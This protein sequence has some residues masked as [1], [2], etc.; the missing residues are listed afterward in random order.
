MVTQRRQQRADVFQPIGRESVSAARY[1]TQAGLVDTA[2]NIMKNLSGKDDRKPPEKAKTIQDAI[3]RGFRTNGE[4]DDKSRFKR[5]TW[6]KYVEG[7]TF[8]ELSEMMEGH[9]GFDE[10]QFE[11]FK[12]WYPKWGEAPDLKK[13][14]LQMVEAGIKAGDYPMTRKQKGKYSKYQLQDILKDRYGVDA[15]AMMTDADYISLDHIREKQFAENLIHDSMEKSPVPDMRWLKSR[16]S[17]LQKEGV[18]DKR[19]AA[20]IRSRAYKT[21]AGYMA[22][23]QNMELRGL[24]MKQLKDGLAD[25]ESMGSVLHL[26]DSALNGEFTM[27]E[28]D[29]TMRDLFR[30]SPLNNWQMQTK[31]AGIRAGV[32]RQIVE[33]VWHKKV[34]KGTGMVPQPIPLG[35]AG[36]PEFTQGLYSE[37]AQL[38]QGETGQSF[39][40]LPKEKRLAYIHSVIR[41]GNTMKLTTQT[42]AMLLKVGNA[43]DI[44]PADMAR[45]VLSTKNDRTVMKEAFHDIVNRRKSWRGMKENDIKDFTKFFGVKSDP[46]PVQKRSGWLDAIGKTISGMWGRAT[47]AGLSDETKQATM[48]GDTKDT[49]KKDGE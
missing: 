15:T 37:A 4:I 24:R 21:H 10:K 22:M 2:S 47:S 32:A 49:A 34:K 13:P 30:E 20:K 6:N 43:F 40:S 12:E 46:K 25:S 45:H 26:A 33:S 17:V 3:M 5:S 19:E 18:L 23:K 41:P 48:K 1:K 27:T 14:F 39:K 29:G 16:L 36:F 7:V 8:A 42:A 11:E 35:V 9:P 31:A 44:S 38:Y 28:F